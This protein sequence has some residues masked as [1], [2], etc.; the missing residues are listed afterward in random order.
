VEKQLEARDV[1]DAA[2]GEYDRLRRQLIP[3]FD[4]FYGMAVDLLRYDVQVPLG[5]LDVGA[6]TGLLAAAVAHRFPRAR[7]ELLDA[8]EG[9][10]A[11]ARKRFGGAGERIRFRLADYRTAPLGGP[12]H[13]VVSALSIHHLED[14]KKRSL[15]AA[16][17]DS[18]LPGG[19][20]VNADNVRADDPAVQALHR[21]AWIEKIRESGVGD[22]DLARALER[23][24]VDV[25]APLELQ[26]DWL[27]DLGFARVAAFY[28]WHH[29]AVFAGW[30][31]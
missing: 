13:A 16:I 25:L 11:R 21:E 22:D 30:R 26:L 12:F 17:F 9:M 3:C 10:L 20:F 23:T 27:R 4:A 8:S 29:F 31:P 28:S 6:G 19:V 5:V 18:L 15:Y 2:A 1:F 24:K 7:I 14:A